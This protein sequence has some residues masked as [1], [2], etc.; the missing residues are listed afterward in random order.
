MKH[1][2]STSTDAA[3]M[4]SMPFAMSAEGAGGMVDTCSAADGSKSIDTSRRAGVRPYC[5]RL[6]AD[7]ADARRFI[8]DDAT[9]KEQQLL[10]WERLDVA[11]GMCLQIES[12]F[13]NDAFKPLRI[14][15]YGKIIAWPR[16]QN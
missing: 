11:A 5:A 1:E 15:R 13:R 9:T 14:A 6:F 7:Y 16:N 12:S 10:A 3:S 2:Y 8:D 4:L